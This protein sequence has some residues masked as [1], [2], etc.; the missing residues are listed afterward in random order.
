M[1]LIEENEKETELRNFVKNKMGFNEKMVKLLMK[2][3]FDTLQILASITENNLKEI[4]ERE[5]QLIP[6]G[7]KN[8]ILSN[9]A[10]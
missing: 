5:Q 7:H 4:E 6:I 9:I 8:L 2:H 3:G 1:L 10:K